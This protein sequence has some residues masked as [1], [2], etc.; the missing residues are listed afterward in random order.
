MRTAEPDTKKKKNGKKEALAEK[1]AND[2]NIISTIA[3]SIQERSRAIISTAPTACRP[4]SNAQ[5]GFDRGQIDPR[6][7]DEDALK[8]T[9]VDDVEIEGL[10][11]E[12]LMTSS[13]VNGSENPRA[14]RDAAD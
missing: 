13:Q 5:R 14:L 1:S 7:L 6:L 11:A 10:N 9:Q 12:V 3:T 8:N 4:H 2:V